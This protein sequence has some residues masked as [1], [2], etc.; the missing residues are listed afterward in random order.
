MKI[1]DTLKEF[2]V[3]LKNGEYFEAH[4][5]LEHEWHKLKKDNHPKANLARGLINAAVAFEHLKRNSPT[6]MD[7]AMRTY[8]GYLKY[9]H[10]A[11]DSEWL[12]AATLVEQMAKDKGLAKNNSWL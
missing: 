3:L 7:K 9:A 5:V 6:A 4:E 11:D 1:I 10:L 2:I 8:K 12:E